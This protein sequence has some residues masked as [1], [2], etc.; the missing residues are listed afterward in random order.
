MAAT[1][2]A[3]SAI[4]LNINISLIALKTRIAWLTEYD[5]EH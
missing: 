1:N 2:T 4:F 3:T 5:V